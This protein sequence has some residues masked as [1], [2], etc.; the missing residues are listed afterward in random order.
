MPETTD[1]DPTVAR[2]MDAFNDHDTERLMAEFAED[3]T[4][5]DP[6]Q[7]EL[8]KAELRAFTDEVFEAFPDV[9]YEQHRVISG[10]E[11]ATAVEVT[12]HAT[13]EGEFDGIPP[14]GQTVA[15]PGVTIVEVSE[16][17]ITS[18][19]DYFDKQSFAEQ[20]GLE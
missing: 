7:D 4:F 11:G 8:N 5:S 12:I 6:F 9:R 19:R 10:S 13:H 2:A 3:V 1:V 20:L 18:W 16:N 15:L 17:G 14:T